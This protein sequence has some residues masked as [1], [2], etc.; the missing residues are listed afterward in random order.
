MANSTKK[1][2]LIKPTVDTPFH[3]DFDWWMDTDTNWRVFLIGF[4]CDTHREAFEGQSDTAEM[5]AVDPDTAEITKVDALLF[6]LINHC[7]QSDDFLSG[8]QPLVGQV[9]RIFLSNG[10]KPLSPDQLA[11][12]TGKPARTIMATIG[13]R[14]VNKG[15]RPVKA[16]SE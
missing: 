3:I 8:N 5:D 4:L 14:R 11:E 16:K 15:I 2:S 1:F 9:F 10:N 6:T 7:A 13:G 12:M